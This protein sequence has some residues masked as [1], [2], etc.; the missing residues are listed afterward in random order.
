VWRVELEVVD[1]GLTQALCAEERARSER[2]PRAGG[3][4]WARSRGVLRAL[5][6]RYL[7]SDPR[8]LRFATSAHGKPQLLGA[9]ELSFNLSHSGHLALYAITNARAVGVDLEILGRSHNTLALAARAFGAAEARRLAQLAPL[10]RELEFLRLWTRHEAVQ[11]CRGTGIGARR[12]PGGQEPWNVELEVG[13]QAAA[14]V[15]SDGAPDEL[16]CLDWRPLG[17]LRSG[18]DIRNRFGHA[19]PVGRGRSDRRLPQRRGKVVQ[20]DG[21]ELSEAHS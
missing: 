4:L 1:D 18:Q 7:G 10:S 9:P 16:R 12:A 20:Y 17:H 5:L 3:R 21:F 14:A 19:G 15:A 2:F 13:T 6:G 8:A 11:K